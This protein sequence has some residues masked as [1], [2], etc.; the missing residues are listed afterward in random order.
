MHQTGAL[1]DTM[2]LWLTPRTHQTHNRLPYQ[3]TCG[4]RGI[5]SASAYRRG[6]G[7]VQERA[8]RRQHRRAGVDLVLGAFAAICSCGA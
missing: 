6:D 2:V 7:L 4:G 5:F 8:R 1:A 3:V